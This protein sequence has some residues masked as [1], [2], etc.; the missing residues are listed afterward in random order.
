MTDKINLKYFDDAHFGYGN[1]TSKD[2]KNSINLLKHLDSEDSEQVDKKINQLYKDL[3]E[4]FCQEKYATN[5]LNEKFVSGLDISIKLDN[6]EYKLSKEEKMALQR[7]GTAENV[8][9]RDVEMSTR[10]FSC[11][12]SYGIYNLGDIL[13][14]GEKEISKSRNFGQKSKLDLRKV[15]L[16]WFPD[17]YN[18]FIEKEN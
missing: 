13:K 10:T 1:F 9:I 14:I 7:Y 11:L 6:K 5:P 16:K 4:I 2:K 15:I 8:D 18:Q 3:I 12:Y 17:K